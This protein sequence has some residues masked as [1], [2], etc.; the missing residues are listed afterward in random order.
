MIDENKK[1][2]ESWTDINKNYA[3]YIMRCC[4]DVPAP[5]AQIFLNSAGLTNW[6]KHMLASIPIQFKH[7]E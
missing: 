1:P 7:L 6:M 5:L 3:A 2:Q 4:F